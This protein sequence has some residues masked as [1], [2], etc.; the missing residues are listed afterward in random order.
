MSILKVETYHQACIL[1]QIVKMR[2]KD[3]LSEGETGEQ[4]VQVHVDMWL[5]L[6]E[7]TRLS[8]NE[9]LGFLQFPTFI[10][11]FKVLPLT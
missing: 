2:F 7:Q 8:Y 5:T 1:I 11:F 6:W 10:R 3:L 4:F 9:N